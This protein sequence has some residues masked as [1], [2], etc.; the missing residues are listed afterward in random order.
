MN[1]A[2]RVYYRLARAALEVKYRSV[3]F[4]LEIIKNLSH[5]ACALQYPV[6]LHI[7]YCCSLKPSLYPCSCAQTMHVGYGSFV[8][9]NICEDLL[10]SVAR[11]AGSHAVS[12]SFFFYLMK[13]PAR[14]STLW[15][16][17]IYI[18]IYHVTT[19]FF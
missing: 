5:A 12:F 4:S 2:A 1:N 10:Y 6:L 19:F 18:Y 14:K 8:G 3:P 13:N 17:Y 9:G 16:I 7:F 15:T 11:Q